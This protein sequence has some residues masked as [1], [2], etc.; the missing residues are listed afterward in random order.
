LKDL[1]LSGLVKTTELSNTVNL[2]ALQQ[3]IIRDSPGY[4]TLS[5]RL[6]NNLKF[7]QIIN[8]PNFNTYS[9]NN[10]AALTNLDLRSNAL[11][12]FSNQ[13][14]L[15]LVALNLQDNQ[16]SEFKSNTFSVIEQLSLDNNKLDTADDLI[17]SINGNANLRVLTLGTIQCYSENN[18]IPTFPAVTLAALEILN[19]ASNQLTDLAAPVAA[20]LKILNV[21]NWAPL[22]RKQQPL[23]A[24]P[25]GLRRSHRSMGK[26]QQYIGRRCEQSPR[27][28]QV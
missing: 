20:K 3:L 26:Q 7:L 28:D 4:T 25:T 2:P 23:T 14:L 15:N 18:Q 8:N 5:G 10:F 9:T 6:F 1:T 19:L 21:G 11:T 27:I 24:T 17:L 22:F 16:V 13:N 12:N